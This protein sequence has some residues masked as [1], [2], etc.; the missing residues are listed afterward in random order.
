MIV[1]GRLARYVVFI[2]RLE[3]QKREAETQ[4]DWLILL[5]TEK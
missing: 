4:W 2:E 3:L 5:L 1:E